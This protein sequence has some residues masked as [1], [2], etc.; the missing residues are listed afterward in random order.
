MS[1]L[2]ALQ[3]NAVSDQMEE[4]FYRTLSDIKELGYDGV[5]FDGIFDKDP[6]VIRDFL[7]ELELIPVSARVSFDALQHDLDNVIAAYTAIG[8]DYITLPCLPQRALP[9]ND[10]FLQTV[11]EIK[12]IGMALR[13]SGIKLLY[14]SQA[15]DFVKVGEEYGLDILCRMTVQDELKLALDAYRIDAC[16]AAPTDFIQKYAGRTPL[17]YLRH[18]M[19]NIPAILTACK[20]SDTHWAIVTLNDSLRDSAPLAAAERSIAYLK[21]LM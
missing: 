17:V 18:G 10:V 15:Y 9:G 13:A 5:E 19:K 11:E 21:P 6:S 4:D 12:E 3:L 2:S 14:H 1:L 16:G 20:K 8:C 7:K